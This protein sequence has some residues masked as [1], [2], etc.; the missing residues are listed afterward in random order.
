[1]S[2]TTDLVA[3]SIVPNVIV[4]ASVQIINMEGVKPQETLS[5]QVQEVASQVNMFTRDEIVTRYI[6]GFIPD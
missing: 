2:P 6:L 3:I 4:S 5:P 1:M